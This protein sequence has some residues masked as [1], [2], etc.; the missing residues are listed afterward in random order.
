MRPRAN[1]PATTVA[2]YA[3]EHWPREH[4]KAVVREAIAA[5]A[6]IWSSHCHFPKPFPQGFSKPFH[7][8]EGRRLFSAYGILSTLSKSFLA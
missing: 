8:P 5:Y 7:H 3:L 4:R 2:R 1:Q 6:W